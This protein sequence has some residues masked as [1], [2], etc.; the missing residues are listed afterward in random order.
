MRYGRKDTTGKGRTLG[1][2]ITFS[3]V[4]TI[5][6]MWFRLGLCYSL[7]SIN[8]LKQHLLGEA[9]SDQHAFL[10]SLTASQN[11]SSQWLASF[12]SNLSNA[13]DDYVAYVTTMHANGNLELT[14]W[15]G[16]A[17]D[18]AC[19]ML[20]FTAI[21]LLSILILFSFSARGESEKLGENDSTVSTMDSDVFP[22]TSEVA[23]A[24]PA[25][26]SVRQHH[27]PM[28]SISIQA[29]FLLEILWLHLW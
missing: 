10:C 23:P 20:T 6:H 3:A 1:A 16:I 4:S 13:W 22:L 2:I 19:P 18:T 11:R 14:S 25:A 27:V 8:W 24:T 9:L 7:Q 5:A 26:H 17:I 29:V 28:S 12:F 21:F 15:C